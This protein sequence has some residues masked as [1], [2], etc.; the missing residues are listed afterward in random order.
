LGI[1]G[2]MGLGWGVWG[3]REVRMDWGKRSVIWV[4]THIHT[5]VHTYTHTHIRARAHAVPPT[6]HL[7]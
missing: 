7:P 6:H 2:W 1:G 4:Y 3:E 5:Y